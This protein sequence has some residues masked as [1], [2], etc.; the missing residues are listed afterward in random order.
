LAGAAAAFGL[1]IK[2]TAAGT[3]LVISVYDDATANNAT[4]GGT[5]ANKL[6][7]TVVAPSAVGTFS[8]A[9]SFARVGTG[10]QGAELTVNSDTVS[11]L[12][13][14]NGSEG[15][16]NFTLHDTTDTQ[17]PSGTVITATATDGAL[18][19]F[20]SG[21]QLGASATTTYGSSD[22]GT[23][24]VAQ[25][26]ANKASNPA[27]TI[28]VN[29]TPWITKSLILLGDAA[30]VK[31]AA[32]TAGI[33]GKISTSGGQIGLSVLDGNGNLLTSKS[34]TI[35]SSS[36]NTSV[37]GFGSTTTSS[38]T[39]ALDVAFTCSSVKGSSDVVATLTNSAGATLTSNTL[40]VYCVGGAYSYTASLD[41]TT[42]A[43]GDVATLSIN[44][45]DSAGNA[46]DDTSTIGSSTKV[47]T[48]AGG[49]GMTI[50]Q[51]P[52]YGDTFTAGVKKYTFTVGTTEGAY[53]VIVDL[54]LLN[55]A[56]G[57]SS[58][59]VPYT[60]KS[61][62]ASVTNAEV[63]AAIVKLIASI[64]KQIAALQKALKK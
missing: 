22:Y 62:S 12:R 34:P 11:G 28:S 24:Y 20:S 33:Y 31:L 59:A 37:T 13:V 46:A 60:V 64:N 2:P 23:V 8:S 21:G 35:S 27:V 42:Y 10:A 43:P 36:Y 55:A 52:S 54:P 30:S 48:I 29:G 49:G 18:V 58:V 19:A 16:I 63:L 3:P 45:K 32:G 40:K 41:K 15:Y 14:N 56:S 26:T 5:L 38:T 1:T 57:Q 9:D 53:N 25:G 17:M 6:T 51:T 44:A 50:V 7:V 61:S 4:A 39:D 47:Q